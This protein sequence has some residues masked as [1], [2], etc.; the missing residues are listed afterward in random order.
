MSEPL[1]QSQVLPYIRGLSR[2]HGWKFDLVAFEPPEVTDDQL[3]SLVEELAR[4]GIAYSWSRR[5]RSHAVAVKGLEAGNAFARLA[6]RALRGRPRVI[7]ARS[8]LP[9]AVGL[10]L[11]AATPGAKLI[12][13]CRG[14][15]ADEY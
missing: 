12:F 2:H 14:L 3:R 8:Y 5:S 13:D 4:D 7:H 9:A 6:V 15:L 11:T 10:A 1:G